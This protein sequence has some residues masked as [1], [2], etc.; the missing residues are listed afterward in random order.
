[1][2]TNQRIGGTKKER[3]ELRLKKLDPKES[4]RRNERNKVEGGIKGEKKKGKQQLEQSFGG[5]GYGKG[6][7]KGEYLKRKKKVFAKSKRWGGLT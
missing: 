3:D 2:F 1:L 4:E 7:T 6:G 5:K